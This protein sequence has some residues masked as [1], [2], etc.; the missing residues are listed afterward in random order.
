MS[1]VQVRWHQWL[2]RT[3]SQ[4]MSHQWRQMVVRKCSFKSDK[5]IFPRVQVQVDSWSTFYE[6][7]NKFPKGLMWVQLC[8]EEVQGQEM[9]STVAPWRWIQSPLACSCTMT[10]GA[11]H[12]VSI[13][14][15]ASYH[16]AQ[17]LVHTHYV[18]VYFKCC[19][20]DCCWVF[21][22]QR[23][24]FFWLIL[25]LQLQNSSKCKEGAAMTETE[26]SEKVKHHQH[27]KCSF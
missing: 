25:L 15:A 10:G 12:S 13:K 7:M 5:Q 18:I 26:V 19:C 20:I 22:Q 27:F 2:S 8:R 1:T 24:M 23:K 3:T 16:V 6:E 21:V 17:T 11:P 4:S 9:T 14:A